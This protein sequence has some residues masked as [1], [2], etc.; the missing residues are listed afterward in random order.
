MIGIT[1][2]VKYSVVFLGTGCGQILTLAGEWEN[3]MTV[4]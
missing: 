1:W 4:S 2:E 3:G